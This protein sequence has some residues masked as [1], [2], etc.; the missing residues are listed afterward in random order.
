[1]TLYRV[2]AWVFT[3]LCMALFNFFYLL[4]TQR[5]T[6]TFGL[7]RGVEITPE[8]ATKL[9]EHV[10]KKNDTTKQWLVEI[11]EEIVPN[12]DHE[13]SETDRED[14]REEE[15]KKED[16]EWNENFPFDM[17]EKKK[18]RYKLKIKPEEYDD[19]LGRLKDRLKGH[20]LVGFHATKKRKNLVGL[21]KNGVDKNK[22]DTGH[23]SG[24]GSGFY[25]IPIGKGKYIKAI[26]A[27]TFWGENLVA[28]YV[29]EDWRFLDVENLARTTKELSEDTDDLTNIY[30]FAEQEAVIPEKQCEKVILVRSP[31]DCPGEI[32]GTER[33][34][35]NSVEEEF[36][37]IEQ[38]TQKGSKGGKK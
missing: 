28:V 26:N 3:Y 10:R 2:A 24:K 35:W 18:P 22:F 13:Q 15:E 14:G 11:F 29:P 17:G 12:Q 1:M 20:K 5:A 16:D 6:K 23:G 19:L 8:E 32:E 9:I 38:L 33:E 36:V 27:A 21:V 30:Q 7:E 34:K 25:F 4:I 31:E 37:F